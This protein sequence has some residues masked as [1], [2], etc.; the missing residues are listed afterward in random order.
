MG[1]N[2]NT[3]P[4]LFTA[5]LPIAVWLML[6]RRGWRRGAGG[7]AVLLLSGE[8]AVAGSRGAIAAGFA[9]AVLTALALAPSFRAKLATAAALVA[10]A[11]A[12]VLTSR[13]QPPAPQAG[14][15]APVPARTSTAGSALSPP[16]AGASAPAPARSAKHPV[17]IDAQQ[18][19]RLEDEL[20]HPPIGDYRPPVPRTLLGTSGR[21]QAWAGAA[22]QGAQRPLLGYG[23]GTEDKVFVDRFY[24]FEGGFPEN[25]YLG[26]FLQLGAVG[27]ALLA[28]L[29]LMLAWTAVRLLRGSVRRGGAGPAGALA[30]VLVAAIVIGVTQSGLVS[31]GNIAASSFWLCA[32]AL[33]A[34]AVEDRG[35]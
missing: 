25:S 14:A 4:M 19:L 28:G 21:A 7:A 2:P 27:V 6:E 34:L 35:S 15:A 20:G 3:V 32:L 33:P 22:D 17:A 10:L 9:G 1:Q 26:V 29:L 16:Q 24:A 12:T 31:V 23:F 8:M 11:I 18:V 5:G 30:G 13:L